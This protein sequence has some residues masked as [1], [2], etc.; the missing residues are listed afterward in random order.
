MNYGQQDGYATNASGKPIQIDQ[1]DLIDFGM[2]LDQFTKITDQT[3]YIMVEEFNEGGYTYKGWNTIMN[4][5]FTVYESKD[6]ALAL[7]SGYK[8]G[9]A[10]VK[11]VAKQKA[12]FDKYASQ[13]VWNCK[14]PVTIPGS[15]KADEIHST[16]FEFVDADAKKYGTINAAGELTPY[17]TINDS[18]LANGK[19]V[20][21]VKFT[22]KD[23]WGMT[24]TKTFDVTIT[25]K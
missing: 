22:V 19:A 6:G 3:F 17:T 20:V 21:K 16:K 9:D 25:K 18:D 14:K 13:L 12:M 10:A 8:A 11:A 2:P 7:K 24:M 1:D 15:S 23:N 4:D 5:L